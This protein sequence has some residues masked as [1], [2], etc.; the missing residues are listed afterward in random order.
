LKVV[1]DGVKGLRAATAAIGA[2]FGE[3]FVIT[4]L[5]WVKS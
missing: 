5:A 3:L 1:L 4:I 2:V